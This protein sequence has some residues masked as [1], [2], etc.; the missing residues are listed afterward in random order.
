MHES[1]QESKELM[2]SVVFQSSLWNQILLIPSTLHQQHNSIKTFTESF[3][4]SNKSTVVWIIEI[5]QTVQM[6]FLFQMD[7]AH[8][9]GT[10]RVKHEQQ[11]WNSPC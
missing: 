7:S 6:I 1:T 3:K 11:K 9:S 5:I 8:W 2:G 10:C 4:L